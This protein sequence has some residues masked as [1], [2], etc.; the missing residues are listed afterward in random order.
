MDGHVVRAALVER[1]R[2]GAHHDMLTCGHRPRAEQVREVVLAAHEV[3]SSCVALLVLVRRRRRTADIAA[4]DGSAT[5]G[6]RTSSIR[7]FRLSRFSSPTSP[8]R[9]SGAQAVRRLDALGIDE[10]LDQ[11][12]GGGTKPNAIGLNASPDA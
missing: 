11:A 7:K 10:D 1:A 6:C 2:A 3:D 12:G 9:S 4:Y 5:F 8:T